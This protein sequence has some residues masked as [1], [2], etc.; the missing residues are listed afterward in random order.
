MNGSWETS[1]LQPTPEISSRNL[2]NKTNR[3]EKYRIILD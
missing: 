2:E 1:S 3:N